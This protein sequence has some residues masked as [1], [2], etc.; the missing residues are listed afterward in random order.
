MGVPPPP[1]VLHLLKVPFKSKLTVRCE[2]R[3][4]IL[5]SCANRES[6]RGSSLAGQKTKDL[7]M[8]DSS[9]ILQRHTAVTQHGMVYSRK[10]LYA[11]NTTNSSYKANVSSREICIKLHFLK[12]SFKCLLQIQTKSVYSCTSKKTNTYFVTSNDSQ[13]IWPLGMIKIC[14]NS[15]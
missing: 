2:S 3:F 15:Q 6:S 8:T 12:Y 5:D 13:I 4:A 1:R 14:C 10:R 9:M 7:P 11:R